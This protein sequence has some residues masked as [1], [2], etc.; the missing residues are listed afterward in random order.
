LNKQSR[1]FAIRQIIGARMVA[2]QDEL[3]QLLEEDGIEVTQATLSR[4]LKEMGVGRVHTTEGIRYLLSSANEESRLAS[5]IGYEVDSIDA[6]EVMVVIRTLP[7]RASG[8]AEII[9]GFRHP[10]VLGTIAGDNTIFIAPTSTKKLAGL[11]EDLRRYVAQ[12]RGERG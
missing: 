10:D 3:R 7:G 11:V 6:N 12:G 8:V 4:D 1:Q 9:D 5:L 2:N